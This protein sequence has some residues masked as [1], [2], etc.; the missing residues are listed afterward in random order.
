MRELDADVVVIGSGCTGGWAA[1]VIAE[2][3]H[4]VLVLEAGRAITA[5][6]YPAAWYRRGDR[7]PARSTER[8]SVQQH[9]PA[10]CESNRGLWIDDLDNPYATDAEA[11]FVW[12][13]ARIEGGRSNLWGGQCWRLS[14]HELAAPAQDGFGPS[15]PLHEVDLATSYDEVE[16]FH[17]LAGCDEP[18][19]EFP[20]QAITGEV[21]LTPVETRMRERLRRDW[22][23]VATQ[24]RSASAAERPYADRGAW[25]RFSS[26]GSTLAAARDTGRTRVVTDAIVARLEVAPGGRQVREAVCIDA[27]SGREIRY[28]ARAFVL[29]ASTIESTRILLASASPSHPHGLGNA[30][31]VL[32]RHLMD[33]IGTVVVGRIAGA[34]DGAESTF[35]GGRHG[36]Y[37]APIG[38]PT[39]FHRQYGCWMSLGR[40][41][42]H[43]QNAVITAIGEMLPYP[44]NKVEL[45]PSRV[46][47]WGLPVP[48]IV[49]TP[50]ENEAAMRRHQSA[51]VSSLAA[52]AG[53][54][55]S[56]PPQ[57]VALGAMVH[58][59]GTARMGADPGSSFC[60]N[61]AQSWEVPNLFV[62]D[63]A[64][65]TT[66]AY[67]NPTL[68]MMALAARTAHF[69]ADALAGRG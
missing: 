29:C 41:M 19:V 45:H 36:L 34:A 13:R 67:Q 7:T 60:N 69:V 32:G 46:D 1:K 56:V 66:S 31:G 27:A 35:F 38:D 44:D 62:P 8:H 54:E 9:H 61:Y 14:R 47:R 68:T 58:E 55:V 15:W 21:E 2:A 28:R 52:M 39:A 43:G 22:D 6:D 53:I 37:L 11:P 3:G 26:L 65:W 64:C 49:C 51:T 17:E 10:F 5:G 48:T 30:S 4:S 24:A 40:P 42:G 50:R 18:G 59:V 12:I 25:P 16:R 57:H 23:R 63:G 20:R 33:H